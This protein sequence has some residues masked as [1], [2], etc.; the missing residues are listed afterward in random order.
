MSLGSALMLLVVVA[1]MPGAADLTAPPNAPTPIVGG[2]PTE[3]GG[4]GSV[5]A[6]V[7]GTGLCT[8]SVVAPRLILTAGHCLQAV[9]HPSEV[10]VFY[11]DEIGMNPALAVETF[12]VH[13]NFCAG[14][15][16]DIHDYGYLV[17]REEFP[18][19]DQILPPIVD[20]AEWD[21]TM[22]EGVAVTVVGY[23]EDPAEPDRGIGRKRRVV[24][25]INRFSDEGL[26][27]FAG[28][29]L[30]DSCEG[31]SGG[32]AFVQLASG[33]WRLAGIVSRGSNPCGDGGFYG[34]P[35]GALPWVRLETEMDLCGSCSTCDCLQT[36]PHSE[37]RCSVG[38]AP[39]TPSSI[40]GLL[41]LGLLGVSRLRR[42]QR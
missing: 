20:Q 25:F 21:Q 41:G 28:G 38:T 12:G 7:V 27:F 23:G 32:P 1:S 31:D 19:L 16:E 33:Q 13:P 24:T 15:E 10:Q 29:D 5:V 30:R 22:A 36:A 4:F 34:V 18:V 9:E 39:S 8:G 6:V 40:L 14:C 17:L 3:P 11:G 37:E 35:Y 2:E 42:R 26:E